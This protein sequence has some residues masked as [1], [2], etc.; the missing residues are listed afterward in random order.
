MRV[1]FV[2]TKESPFSSE[3]PLGDFEVIQFGISFISSFLKQYGHNTRLLVLTRNSEFSMIDAYMNEFDPDMI[4]FTAVASEYTFIKKIAVYMKTILKRNVF[5]IIGGP[6]VSIMPHDSMLETFDALCIGEGEYPVIE[7]LNQLENN[8]RP[9]GIKNLWIKQNNGIEK[10]PTRP[11]IPDIDVIPQADRDIWMEWVDL[12]NPVKRLSV[13]LGR[14]C[15]FLCTYCSNHS[16]KKL[17]DGKYVRFRS[18]DKV[19][20]EIKSLLVQFPYLDEVYFEVETIGVNVDWALELADK[21]SAF[22]SKLSRLLTFGVNY[23]ITPNIQR[24]EELFSALKKSNF[25]FINFGL[26]SGSEAIRL[27]V[28]KRNYS[29][30]DF[31]N[32]V[33]IAKKYG[34]K[35]AIFNLIGL[36]FEKIWDFTETVRINR[37]CQPDWHLLSIFYPYP[38]TDLYNVCRIN[39]FLPENLLE[40]EKERISAALN[41][42]DFSKKQIQKAY[43][44]FDYYVY[45]G[46]RK[47]KS[48][49]QEIIDKYLIV[50]Q[51]IRRVLL[52]YIILRDVLSPALK[53]YP[54]SG[55]LLVV[56]YSIRWILR[57][58]YLKFRKLI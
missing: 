55:E 12:K 44:W 22:N 9:S 11:F 20:S 28:L 35:I 49:F 27:D 45:K 25:R 37:I 46:F 31:L 29:N 6:H 54:L 47:N 4:C 19:I 18:V 30:E 52:P 58:I 7:A 38:G 13:L 36:P 40:T 5:F 14:G 2:Y 16:L 10:N 21:L 23:R 56:P 41:F 34:F 43:I 57:K 17:A 24:T 32:T 42:P 8:I 51:G 3:K 39:G 15:P 1:L 53:L 26:E 50:V 33:E 48:L